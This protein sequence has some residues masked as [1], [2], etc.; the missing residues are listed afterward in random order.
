MAQ[1]ALLHT[2]INSGLRLSPRIGINSAG[3]RTWTCHQ[4]TCAHTGFVITGI[5]NTEPSM[6]TTGISPC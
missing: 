5:K 1:V 3:G 6:A 4:I 2:E